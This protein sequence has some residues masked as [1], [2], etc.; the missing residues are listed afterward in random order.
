VTP[1]WKLRAAFSETLERPPI[2]SSSRRLITSYDTPVTRSV[3]YSNPYL[4]PIHSTNFDA[5]AEYYYG[6]YDAH[7]SI[8]LFSK[9]LRDLPAVSSNQSLG[10]DGVREIVSYTSNVREVNGKKVYGRSRGVEWVWSDPQLGF[11]P[12][13]LGSLGIT[14]AYDYIAYQTTAVNGGNGVPPTDT[15]LVDS[16]PRGFFSAFVAYHA[17]PF[18]ANLSVQHQSS[19]PTM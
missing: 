13:R 8:G 18:A 2:N 17:G 11:F 15:R 7:V 16:A 12:T 4:L 10:A 14:L 9:Y 3:S 1:R 6:P 5:S 19:N